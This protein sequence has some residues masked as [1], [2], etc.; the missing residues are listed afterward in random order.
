MQPPQPH[1]M[2]R[3][4]ALLAGVP[5]AGLPALAAATGPLH[6]PW[7]AGLGT[8][9]LRLPRLEGGDWT[10]A[11]ARGQP[12]LLNFWASWCE[13]CR[14]EMPSLEQLAHRHAADGLQVVAVNFREGEAA[15]T[16]FQVATGLAL[17]VVRDADGA[18]ARAFGVRIFPASVAIG[19]DGRARFTVVGEADWA[20]PSVQAWLAPLLRPG[21]VPPPP[22]R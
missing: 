6:R 21:P 18:A 12:V 17:P 9:A 11:D 15:I 22:R 7:P 2:S 1:P 8:P 19:R 20:A 5:L 14:A 10:L 16:R 13:P 4:Q 3:R